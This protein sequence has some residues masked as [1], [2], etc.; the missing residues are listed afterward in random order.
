MGT[1]SLTLSVRRSLSV[2]RSSFCKRSRREA[3]FTPAPEDVQKDARQSG[4]P[5]IFQQIGGG[6]L[7]HELAAAMMPT[8]S[9]YHPVRLGH[10]SSPRPPRR[11]PLIL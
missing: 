11:F 10:G 5:T 4:F 9:P 3:R 2:S 6:T 7:G 8:R 1:K